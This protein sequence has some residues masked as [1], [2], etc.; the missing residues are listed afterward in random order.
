MLAQRGLRQ[1]GSGGIDRCERLLQR[2]VFARR[3]ALW[4]HHLHAEIAFSRLAQGADAL[5]DSKLLLLAG[6]KIQEA[7]KQNAAI[8][9][10]LAYQAAARA[11]RNLGVDDLAF[12]LAIDTRLQI[13]DAHQLRFIFVA[14]RQM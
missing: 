12:H 13:V 10:Q 1:A 9:F 7:K 3:A 4:V 8:V 11:K 14:Q 6:I 2:G 5:A